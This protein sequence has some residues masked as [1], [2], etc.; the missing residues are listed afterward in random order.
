MSPRSSPASP[1]AAAPTIPLA[2]STP[3]T[4]GPTAARS[5][6]TSLG[7]TAC[8]RW[9]TTPPRRAGRPMDRP[10]GTA[11]PSRPPSPAPT[12]CRPTRPI[13]PIPR[14]RQIRRTRPFLP[15]RK[16]RSC[17]RR[18]CP[19][20][21]SEPG[22]VFPS[23]PRPPRAGTAGVAGLASS[24]VRR[25]LARL[26]RIRLHGRH[27]SRVTVFVD[28]RRV[29]ARRG[30]PLQRLLTVR[31][32]GSLAP[33]PHRVTVRVRF[34]LGSGSRPLTLERRVRICAAALPRFT[35]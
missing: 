7:R 13:R 27:F 3:A 24:R 10:S 4:S 31:R 30:R 22:A 12:C 6:P 17:P 5:R 19:A 11:A 23:V 1:T 33:G 28:G 18:W 35:G 34:R 21:P 2:R 8:S 15:S 26:P 25:C 20:S 14:Y 29:R 9:S 16:R 32:L